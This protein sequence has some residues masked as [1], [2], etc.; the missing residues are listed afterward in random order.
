[1]FIVGILVEDEDGYICILS[2]FGE[3]KEKEKT[4]SEHLY[5]FDRVI[6]RKGTNSVK[7]DLQPAKG[8]ED[9]IS[10]YVADMDFETV[11]AVKK[12]LHE[13]TERGI[14][15]YTFI[16]DS[17]REAVVGWMSRRHDWQI[18][19][20]WIVPFP[21]V[22]PSIKHVIRTYTKPGDEILVFKPVYYPFDAS[23]HLND[24]KLVE[25]PLEEKDGKYT[26]NFE[27]LDQFLAEH[28]VKMVIF[29]SPHNPIGRVWTREE[30]EKLG[31]LA[32][33]YDLMIFSDEIHM[34]FHAPDHPF[35]S[36]HK[37]RPDLEDRLIIATAPSKTFN[38]AGLKNS[39][40]IIPNEELRKQWI[41][42]MEA[43]GISTTPN[44]YGMTATQAAYE[45]GDQWVDELVEYVNGNYDFMIDWFDKNMPMV[46]MRKPEGLY[47]AW[48][49]FRE[50][51]MNGD[52]L[53]DFMLKEAKVW[54]DEGF[55][56]G[57]GGE[58]Y[59]RFNCGTSRSV[60]KEALNRIKAAWEK[61]NS[62][63]Q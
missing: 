49:D 39:N 36:F 45:N 33:K 63:E 5:D 1:M 46:H 20:E 10:L 7:W 56:F 9:L 35:V 4:L 53:E 28:K 62:K 41:H 14:Y 58:G 2:L 32:V 54:L 21:G 15:G 59:E 51:G 16:P 38:L 44:L 34:D 60:I 40:I 24:R 17:Y 22:V 47:L 23:I 12:A 48:V 42:E 50:L 55:I 19:P 13:L 61:R 6:D 27:K 37:A 43:C 25:F 11:P 30:L 8:G 18:Q 29:C 26:I 52:E 3:Q 31:D 57:T